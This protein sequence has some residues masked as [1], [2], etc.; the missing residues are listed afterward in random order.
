MQNG[1]VK[2][3][4]PEAPAL[5]THFSTLM[6]SFSGIVTQPHR[7]AES[8]IE[9]NQAQNILPSQSSAI[10]ELD[11][12]DQE[13]SL[14][15]EKLSGLTLEAPDKTQIFSDEV[16]VHIFHQ[17]PLNESDLLALRLVSRRFCGIA[18]TDTY[19]QLLNTSSAQADIHHPIISE[20]D[21]TA[22]Y[23][24]QQDEFNYLLQHASQIQN[25]YG[26]QI[27]SML[28]KIKH[29]SQVKNKNAFYLYKRHQILTQINSLMICDRI[30]LEKSIL[31]CHQAFI[32]RFPSQLL[33]REQLRQYFS[34]L[35]SINLGNNFLESLPQALF[36]LPMLKSLIA[37]H[38][39]IRNI[40]PFKPSQSLQ[41][42]DLHANQIR[43]FHLNVAELP[44]LRK[45]NLA[46]NLLCNLPQSVFALS[47]HILDVSYNCLT[48][49]K[50]D[51]PG[52]AKLQLTQRPLDEAL[53]TSQMLRRC[54]I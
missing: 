45:L 20:A 30:N 53:K 36:K 13:M 48:G 10:Q 26:Q 54:T 34:T 35:K 16:L 32:T 15:S 18:T 51:F 46:Y 22:L 9:T 29:I 5:L 43:T 49:L 28:E 11:S 1:P 37:S 31:F 21:K 3:H 39:H 40:D 6:R 2:V 33:H 27:E 25:T 23:Q 14:I 41:L 52:F 47:Q 42:L 7:P 24:R 4:P 12:R 44:Q 8:R 50:P 38:N 17:L 19:L